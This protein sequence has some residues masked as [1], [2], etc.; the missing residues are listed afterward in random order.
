MQANKLGSVGDSANSPNDRTGSKSATVR[1]DA[2]SQIRKVLYCERERE[3]EVDDLR[4]DEQ[5]RTENSHVDFIMHWIRADR[6]NNRYPLYFKCQPTTS[7]CAFFFYFFSSLI[8][9]SCF[10]SVHFPQSQ[11]TSRSP[12]LLWQPL[13]SEYRQRTRLTQC[14][15]TCYNSSGQDDDYCCCCCGCWSPDARSCRMLVNFSLSVRQCHSRRAAELHA[16]ETNDVVG[17]G[18]RRPAANRMRN[19]QELTVFGQCRMCV[20]VLLLYFRAV[21]CFLPSSGWR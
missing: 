14:I 12:W 20:C 9:F 13:S 6:R 8:L 17:P 5:Q 11:F 2:E 15:F 19:R 10:F 18:R 7:S 4:R 3:R 16:T 1:R 21:R